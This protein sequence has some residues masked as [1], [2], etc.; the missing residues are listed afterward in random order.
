MLKFGIELSTWSGMRGGKVQLII[1]INHHSIGS[2]L[3]PFLWL[4]GTQHSIGAFLRFHMLGSAEVL[5]YLRD[6]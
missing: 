6:G 3:L 4:C 1:V 5:F 2:M